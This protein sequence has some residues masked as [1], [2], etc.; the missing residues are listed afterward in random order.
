MQQT[1]GLATNA[2]LDELPGIRET[3]RLLMGISPKEP[4][5]GTWIW[6]RG[7]S[8]SV[9]KK[10]SETHTDHAFWLDSDLDSGELCMTQYV[11]QNGEITHMAIICGEEDDDE[12]IFQCNSCYDIEHGKFNRSQVTVP[13][14]RPF[15]VKKHWITWHDYDPSQMGSG[16]LPKHLT[17]D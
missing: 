9:M 12:P 6:Y 3:L 8:V 5:P 16:N 10:V 17:W 1:I 15:Q 11:A 7:F 4:Q 14:N 13:Q 2:P